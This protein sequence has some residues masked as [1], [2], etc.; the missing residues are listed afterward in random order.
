MILTEK[1]YYGKKANIEYMSYSQFKDFCECPAMAI[2]KIKGKYKPESSESMLVGSYVDAFLDNNFEQFKIQTPEIFTIKGELKA[3]FK[4]A[5]DICQIIKKDK[6]LYKLLTGERQKILICNIA[7]VKFKTKLDSLLQ[8]FII[9]GKVVKDCEDCWIDGEKKSFI[10]KYRYDLQAAIYQTAVLQNYN[11]KLPFL[12]AVVTKET[13]P[14]KRIFKIT[15]ET[16]NNAMQ[17]IIVKAPIFNA[18]KKGETEIYGCGKCDYCK[19]IK[20]LNKKN[21]EEI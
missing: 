9:D 5:D 8:N 6:Y 11:K 18:M 4:K 14:D 21:I 15:D 2:A 1:N 19:S 20:K 13:V 17:E 3:Q 7:G 16:I 10:F 12:L